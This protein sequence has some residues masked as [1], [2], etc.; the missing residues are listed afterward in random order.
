MITTSTTTPDRYGYGRCFEIADGV[1]LDQETKT[2]FVL[3][4]EDNVVA[5]RR[6]TPDPADQE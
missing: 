6:V 4:L 1:L 2:V 5:I 3:D